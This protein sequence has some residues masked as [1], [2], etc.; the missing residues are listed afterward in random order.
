MFETLVKTP[1]TL[2]NTCVA[3]VKHMQYPDETLATY[4]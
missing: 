2:E 1:K 4:V 3:I